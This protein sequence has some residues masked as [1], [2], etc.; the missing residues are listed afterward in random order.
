MDRSL[1][2]YGYRPNTYALHEKLRWSDARKRN[3]RFCSLQMYL[4]LDGMSWHLFNG[5]VHFFASG[6]QHWDFRD[7][8][9][10]EIQKTELS[11]S[12]HQAS[13][14]PI[15]EFPDVTI[16]RYRDDSDAF[17]LHRLKWKQRSLISSVYQKYITIYVRQHFDHRCAVIF[18][19][20][21]GVESTKRA[22]QRRR[23]LTKTSLTFY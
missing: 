6:E 20:Y 14:F 23:G 22:E 17:L 12:V 11:S 8:A 21:S 9:K 5:E 10:R 2:G 3:F 15:S 1:V 7:H 4:W 18:D 16:N 19:G 13:P